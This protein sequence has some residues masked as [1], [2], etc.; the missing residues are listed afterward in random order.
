MRPHSL[1]THWYLHNLVPLHIER[2]PS[3]FNPQPQARHNKRQ[4]CLACGCG[5]NDRGRFQTLF[6]AALYLVPK[7]RESTA[8]G[9]SRLAPLAIDSRRFA[10]GPVSDL[11]RYA[12]N[13]TGGSP[14][15]GSPVS[16]LTPRGIDNTD[17]GHCSGCTAPARR[18]THSAN[19]DGPRLGPD[20]A[21]PLA[22]AGCCATGRE[23]S[24]P[25]LET[26]SSDNDESM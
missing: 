12:P 2:G 26:R 23:S 14:A 16:G 24:R 6:N 7:G 10:A 22:C 18:S 15:S 4:P 20:R 3:S 11:W 5:L 8:R 19:A 13:R 17:H 9:V 25:G 1:R 21:G